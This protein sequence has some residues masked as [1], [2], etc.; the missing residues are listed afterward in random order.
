VPFRV[1]ICFDR[2]DDNTLPELEKCP[3]SMRARIHLLKNE[4]KGAHGAICTGFRRSTAPAVVVYPADDDYNPG[5]LDLMFHKWKDEHCEIV[6]ASRF[7]PGGCMQGCPWL[8]ATLVRGAAF[9]LYHLAGLPTHDPSNGFRLFS[10]RVLD[11]F[12]IDSTAGFVYSIELLVKAHRLG[13]SIGETPFLWRERKAGKS[14]FR[15]LRWLPQ[16]L[17]W[18]FYAL[19]TTFLRLGPKTVRLRREE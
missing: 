14:R 5:V 6:A 4:G 1:Q 16:Y 19:G 9:T 13:W 15:T 7:I 18:L 12:A 3:D 10:R 8:K 17:R 11:H 2:D